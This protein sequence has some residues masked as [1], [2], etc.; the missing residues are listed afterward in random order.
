MPNHVRFGDEVL[1]R[2]F[3]HNN[4]SSFVRQLNMYGFHK[5]PHLQQGALKTDQPSQ[6]E[7]WEF[8]NPCFHRDHPD[9]LSKVQRKRSGKDKEQNQQHLSDDTNR[10][11]HSLT[12]GALT[13]NEY[14]TMGGDSQ[15]LTKVVGPVQLTALLGAI[16][17]I[18]SN[19]HSIFEEISK[20][21]HS[22]QA[23]W[24]QGLE[25]R[26]QMR[27]QQDTINRILRFL[28]GV[29]GSSN[30]G[31]ILHNVTGPEL[32]TMNGFAGASPYDDGSANRF[33]EQDATTVNTKQRGPVRPQKRA[34][35]LIS[36]TSYD[37]Q[38]A[39]HKAASQ[40]TTSNPLSS[41]T[42]DQRFSEAT[43]D[44]E[45]NSPNTWTGISGPLP[46]S[47]T[48]RPM[49]SR[50]TPLNASQPETVTWSNVT[51]PPMA[52]SATMDA[53]SPQDVNAWLSS[54]LADG[55]PAEQ[56]ALDPQVL[57]ALQTAMAQEPSSSTR[58]AGAAPTTQSMAPMEAGAAQTHPVTNDVL[59]SMEP[60]WRGPATQ[61]KAGAVAEPLSTE[62]LM[63]SVQR[64]SEEAQANM[65]QTNH[66]QNQIHTL[67]QNLRLGPAQ[68]AATGPKT[69]TAST[70]KLASGHPGTWTN[71]TSSQAPS[72]HLETAP[73]VLSQHST[74]FGQVPSPAGTGPQ[75]AG[76]PGQG[77]DFDL[78]SFLNQFVDPMNAPTGSSFVP[79]SSP[80][81]ED[82]ATEDTSKLAATAATSTAQPSS[83]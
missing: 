7:L 52:N 78:D 56:Q 74:G 39:Q 12:G 9:L 34:R 6:S 65:D 14:D 10:A 55:G 26:Q 27:R 53:K 70:A 44:S 68:V 16:Q 62:Q 66:L 41:T 59:S 13:R 29:F 15:D 20:L 37:E 49:A 77:S 19:Q 11:L 5:V 81:V 8:T 67:V 18:K 42:N 82:M 57:A 54:M 35:F 38:M 43:S 36:D 61:G 51:S 64:I 73:S 31:D 45:G 47:P 30:V 63:R 22:N 69:G 46:D 1:P 17:N 24:Q 28:A 79:I 23:L 32:A 80:G 75:Q 48:L 2:F 40:D 58:P 72:S 4:F 25:N 3:K 60:T 76:T 50:A 83:S 71:P 21:Q 33:Q